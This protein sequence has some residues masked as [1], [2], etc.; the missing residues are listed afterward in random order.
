LAPLSGTGP[1]QFHG[2]K[3]LNEWISGIHAILPDL[4]FVLDVGPIAD[5]QHLTAPATLA[6]FTDAEGAGADCQVGAQ[7]LPCA[8]M[9][10]W[11]HKT[12]AGSGPGPHPAD[13]NHPPLAYPNAAITQKQGL[14]HGLRM[15]PDRDGSHSRKVRRSPA[16]MRTSV[17][18]I[19]PGTRR[20]RNSW[21]PGTRR[22][23]PSAGPPFATQPPRPNGCSVSVG[24][25]MPIASV[26]IPIRQGGCG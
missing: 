3:P 9:L 14:N 2:R 22:C 23:E 11:L 25:Q 7:R 17:R 10:D 15:P 1:D 21:L 26:G 5:E 18:R 12:L 20:D 13:H 16:G 24:L 8:R 4:S 19:R 6:S